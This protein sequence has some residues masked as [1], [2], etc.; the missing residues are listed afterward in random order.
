MAGAAWACGDPGIQ[1]ASTI[2][3][4]HTCPAGGAIRA[5]NPCGEFLFLDDTACNLASLNLLRYLDERGAFRP[6]LYRADIVLLFTAMEAI[7]DSSSYPTPRIARL[8][9]R[10][11]PLGLGYA[12]LGALLMSLGL[13]YDSAPARGW[14]AALTALLTGEAYR[15]SARLAAERGA[16]EAYPENRDALL[17]VL[18][19]HRDGLD[20]VIDAPGSLLAAAREAWA[21]ALALAGRHGVRHAQAT[22]IAPTGTIAFLMDCD[23][24]GIEPDLSLVKYKRLA[25]GGTLKLENHTVPRALRTLGYGDT[26]IAE[27][28]RHV[29]REETIEGAPGLHEDH[30]AVFDCA[31][32]PHRGARAIRP[33]GHLEMMAAVQPFLSGGISKTVNLP[34]ETGI[35]EV[36]R[37]FLRGGELGLKSLTVYRENSKGVQPLASHCVVEDHGGCCG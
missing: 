27:I 30:L 14:A 34:E 12:N 37:L 21:D 2:D 17:A 33:D 10:Y 18:E 20:G 32:R 5:S 35:D 26:A 8:S 25:G 29:E 31:F 4:W 15:T 36:E 24:T 6:D 1:Y 23:T 3:R 9:R 7:V 28:L 16:F 19:R 13:P 22:L 11:R